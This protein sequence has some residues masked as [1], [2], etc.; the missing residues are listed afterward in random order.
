MR[1]LRTRLAVTLVLLVTLTVALIGVGVYAFVDASLRSSLVADAR[2]QADFDLSVLLPAVQ[3]PPAD[4]AAFGASGLPEQFRLRG[5]A[6]VIADF[7][8]G[9]PWVPAGLPGALDEV[10]PA[11]RDI[12]GRGELGYAWQPLG[13][14]PSLVVGG[15]Q[16]T[17][18]AIYLAFPARGVEDALAQ[19]RLGLAAG[20]LIAILV[21]LV[22]SGL[23][24]RGILR[25]VTSGA[26]VA[27]RIADGDLGARVPTGGTIEMARWAEDF[28]RMAD[29]LLA[30]VTRLE[31]AEGQNRRFVADVTHELRTPLTALLAEA[32]VLE[33]SLAALPPDGRRAGELLVAD[34]RRM[35]TLVDDLLE[36]SRFDAD[37]EQA[38][39]QAIDL[40]RLVTA[41]VAARHPAASVVLPSQ[42]VVVDSDPRRL[43]RILGN[44]L[45]N[46]A[47]HAPGAAVEVSLTPV[48]GG[49]VIVVADRGP[50]V[51]ADA[52]PHLFERFWKAD[53]SRAGA[54]A[55]GSSGLGL[56]IAAENAALLGGSLR[57]RNRPGGGLIVALTV[58]VTRSLP[59]GDGSATPASDARSI[60]QPARRAG[61]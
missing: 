13:G 23:I 61:S 43:E 57:A 53:P 55:G 21:A 52:L 46:A 1:S 47:S 4:A 19:L 40:G 26:A 14:E 30:T 28:N 8:D 9:A 31:A 5:D 20:G 54:A 36:I 32:S 58:P 48:A 51:P 15:R 59:A 37:V 22:V 35:R 18:P 24:A 60:E 11:L 7:G 34:V 3:P 16:G 29:S 25:P 38:S 17:G 10:S 41:V 50:G 56:A 45:D 49:A 6:R 39:I 42:P 44:L 2:R 27:R 12:V 33:S